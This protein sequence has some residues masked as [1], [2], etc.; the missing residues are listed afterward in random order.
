MS[1]I[2]LISGRDGYYDDEGHWRRTKFCFVSCGARCTCSPPNG[3]HFRPRKDSK[4]HI[5]YNHDTSMWRASASWWGGTF[6]AS[7]WYSMRYNELT[8]HLKPHDVTA[9]CTLACRALHT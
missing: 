5:R 3:Q 1:L 9:L 7:R 6:P 2:D 8:H 4:P